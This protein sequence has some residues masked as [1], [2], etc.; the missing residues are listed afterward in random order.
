MQ[1]KMRNG[2]HTRADF[3]IWSF[4]GHIRPQQ[5]CLMTILELEISNPPCTFFDEEEKKGGTMETLKSDISRRS[6]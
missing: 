2:L 6:P 1:K 3:S 5:K 4:K